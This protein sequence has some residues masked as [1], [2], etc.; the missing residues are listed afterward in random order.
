MPQTCKRGGT[1]RCFRGGT[2]ARVFGTVIFFVST[3]VALVALLSGL[4]AREMVRPPRHTVGYALAK[5]LPTDPGDIGMEFEEWWLDRPD[6]VRLPVWEVTGAKQGSLSRTTAV[7]VHGWGHSRID[8]LAHMSA[9]NDRF[10]RQVF[11]DLRG[12]G[13]AE[14][15]LSMLGCREDDDLLALLERLGDGPF[16]LIGYSMGAVIAMA[17]AA[18]D[19]PMREQIAC[20]FA[21]APY[22]DFHGSLCGRLRRAAQPTRPL[23]DVAM[24]WL[25]VSGRPPRSLTADDLLAIECPVTIMHGAADTISS[26]RQVCWIAETLAQRSAPDAVQRIVL[27]GVGHEMALL[28]TGEAHDTAVARCCNTLRNA[29]RPGTA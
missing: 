26:P 13:D 5:G 7:F 18:R 29:A 17:A 23:T 1:S 11:Y 2:L 16:V 27:P 25:R 22:A 6:G 14:G 19:H 4:I 15:S 24:A 10:I 28:S 20:L 9:W 8:M 3:L 12:H 21:Y